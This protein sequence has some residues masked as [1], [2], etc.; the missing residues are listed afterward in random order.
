M[1]VT[2][3]AFTIGQMVGPG[4]DM[5]V[6]LVGHGSPDLEA[7]KEAE[8]FIES[9]RSAAPFP[10]HVAYLEFQQ[11][12]V[13]SELDRLAEAGLD[14]LVVVPLVLLP[15]A[16][17]S[18][19]LPEMLRPLRHRFRSGIRYAEPLARRP[20]LLQLVRK[21]AEA[22]LGRAELRAGEA[23]LLVVARGSRVPEVRRELADLAARVA[24]ELG[25]ADHRCAY[26]SVARP[27]L[28]EVLAEPIRRWTVVLPLFA[29]RGALVKRVEQTVR[30]AAER[31][32]PLFVAE[33]LG[34]DPLGIA[35]VVRAAAEARAGVPVN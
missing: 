25:F 26:V 14:G 29:F 30:E 8:Q 22:V 6:L 24:G 35:A 17:W 31:G 19:D 4:P 11:P 23:E 3:G 7:V 2:G 1:A 18:R 33:H 5:P 15:G 13:R 10:V 20:E 16:H 27:T 9:V 12:D 34:A 32:L 28:E 21:R